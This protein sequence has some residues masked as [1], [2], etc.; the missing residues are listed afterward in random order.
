MCT[1]KPPLSCR[2][3]S[4]GV[5]IPHLDDSRPAVEIEPC[6]PPPLGVEVAPI[7]FGLCDWLDGIVINRFGPAPLKSSTDRS[8]SYVE[9]L[10]N[11]CETP[12]RNIRTTRPICLL[13]YFLD[14]PR[15]TISCR[16]DCRESGPSRLMVVNSTFDAGAEAPADTA[17]FTG[18]RAIFYVVGSG[19]LH[20]ASHEF[21]GNDFVPLIGGFLLLTLFGP[22]ATIGMFCRWL[23]TICIS[24]RPKRVSPPG[25]FEVTCRRGP[26]ISDE[27]SSSHIVKSS[28]PPPASIEWREDQH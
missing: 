24:C 6:L 20:V 4:V 27:N 25:T 1:S 16:S 18:R 9:G 22:L 2:R 8:D 10:T 26:F 17:K 28:I 7:D 3:P 19:M 21:A 13:M 12:Q 5:N 11:S 14:H 15:L 23:S